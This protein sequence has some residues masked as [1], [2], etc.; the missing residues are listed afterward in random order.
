MKAITFYAIY[1][2]LWCVS[3][4]SFKN[5]YRVSNGLRFIL[6]KVIGYRKKVVKENLLLCFPEKS[7]EERLAIEKKFYVHLCDLF[8]EM[9]KTLNM[10]SDEIKDRF[11]VKNPEYFDI[12]EKKNQS[13]IFMFGHYASYEWSMAAQLHTDVIIYG[14]YKRLK[15]PYFDKL[16]RSI[17]SKFGAGLIDKNEVTKKI[18]QDKANNKM[19][20]YGMVADQSP[21]ATF[22]AHW[23]TFMG[24]ETPMFVG[25]E[26]MAKRTDF[27]VVYYQIEK[28]KRGYYT[29][30]IIPL[31]ENPSEFSNFEITDAYFR[32]LEKQIHKQPEYYFW[33]HK[34]WKHRKEAKTTQ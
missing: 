26:I 16:V 1:P 23:G 15:N 31:A 24:T 9:I 34:R 21:K 33:T 4:L 2:L 7:A 22:N 13:C 10:T 5:L 25:S 28:I 27:P 3:R 18:A 17:R 14:I 30:E 29:A 19:A 32:L 8:M 12:L 20:H 11:V 6:Y